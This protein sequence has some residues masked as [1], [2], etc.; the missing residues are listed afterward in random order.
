[1]RKSDRRVLFLVFLAGLFAIALVLTTAYG[2]TLQCEN[3]R[4]LIQNRYIIGDIQHLDVQIKEHNN[5][6]HIE[7]EAKSRLGMIY[8]SEDQI[9]YLSDE[10][11]PGANFASVI[12]KNIYN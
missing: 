11:R 12:R 1:M 5:L 7:E 3:N 10:D 9:V 4:L 6:G 2:A 8:P